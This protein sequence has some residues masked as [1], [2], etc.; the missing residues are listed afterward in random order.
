MTDLASLVVRMQADNSQYIK[1]LNQ[2]TSQL[3]SFVKDVKAQLED[4][5]DTFAAA[6]S[7]G[8][9]AD[10]ADHAIE[11]AASLEQLSQSAGISVESLSSLR[12][13]FAAGNLSQDE[14]A[15]SLK[16]LNSNISEAAGNAESKGGVAFR[17]LGV[18]VTDANGNLRDAGAVMAD[19]ANKFQGLA[20][21]PN[22]AA[23]A[24]QLFGR[25]GQ[26]LIPVLNQG[27]AGLDTF[28]AQAEAAGI[29]LSGPLAAA[30]DEFSSK[31]SVIKATLSEGFG[32]QLAAQLLP[33]LSTLADQFTE[34]TSSGEAFSVVA[35]VIVGAVK[36]VAATVV[37]AVSEFKQLGQSIGALGAVAV[38]AASGDFAQAGEIW[39]QSNADNVKTTQQAQDQITAIF[40]AGTANQLSVI[41]TAEAQKKKVKPQAVD[42]TGI[43]Q[44]D[45]AV[46]TLTSFNSNLKDQAASFGLGSAALVDY[47]LQFGPLADAIG[48]A[49]DEGK[50]LAAQIRASA[51]ALSTKQDTK[52]ITD[53]TDK[54]QQQ[55]T[56]FEQGD[57]AAVKYQES[58][59]KL[60]EA[61]ARSADGGAAA[62]V[63]IEALAMSLTKAQD[64]N[65]LFHVDQQLQTLQGHLVSAAAAA[66]DFSNKLLIKNL[67][68]TG[69][70]AGQGQLQQLKDATTAQAAF[71][72][73]QEKASVIQLQLTTTTTN[74]NALKESGAITDMQYGA[75]LS[76]AQ[77]A[78]VTQLN[79]IYAA[80]Q[81]ISQQSGLPKL[82][83]DTQ[84]FA[85]Q[86]TN[87][88]TQTNALTNS[89]RTNLESAFADDF[90]KLIQGG[91][92]FQKFLQS[93]FKG[94][95][96]Q[97]DSLVSKNISQA[98]FGTGGPAGGA[99]GG[100]ASL[101]GGGS[102]PG[103]GGG[104]SS[105]LGIV[106]LGG[107]GG[108]QVIPGVVQNGGT[109]GGI[110]NIVGNFAS[111]GTIPSG[112]FGVVGENGPEL[113]YS[114]AA[115]MNIV[116]PGG[117]KPISVTN[118]FTAAT[119][120]GQISRPSQMQ[121]AAAAARSLQQASRRNN[122]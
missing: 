13:A 31:F 77:A 12:L 16:K 54:L 111:G 33:V 73:Q 122:T 3:T 119:V 106:G 47:K 90:S 15:S 91:E 94:V 44:S 20:D 43:E 22:K 46:K 84:N 70:T 118:N 8:A 52:E 79:Q 108:S 78:T 11:S 38:A 107:G 74:L 113:A 116:P 28:R 101:F 92:S 114:G 9:L 42:L 58:T 121:Q 37:E 67:A 76:A 80:E 63:Q 71:N 29:V 102:T 120:G 10:F 23:I 115:N 17:A 34:S 85:N 19:V 35:G 56:K 50:V 103:G 82:A 104:L 117:S 21:G 65:A 81:L 53:F 30:A 75:Q 5:A 88:T 97:I 93:F 89:V 41:S 49:G 87:L 98:I 62:R 109:G 72:E 36:I 6:F 51:A 1:A 55:V 7:V 32:N 40:E 95:E 2:S 18:S 64:A 25:N 61:L 4:L 68:D 39:R 96:N 86:I 24:I 14:M 69:D 60:G 45:A 59:G 48:K 27:A 105:L 100:I 99:A 57:V 110:G 112:K 83:Q 66:F 26:S